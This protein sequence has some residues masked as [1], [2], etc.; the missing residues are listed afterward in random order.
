MSDGTYS[1]SLNS[2]Y[3][4]SQ[5]E[6]Q[7][8]SFSEI[9]DDWSPEF[10]NSGLMASYFALVTK[11]MH[12]LNTMTP[13]V[14]T[15]SDAMVFPV[16]VINDAAAFP[17]K[18]LSNATTI[19]VAIIENFLTHPG[20]SLSSAGNIPEVNQGT[21]PQVE[22]RGWKQ[23]VGQS[24][25]TARLEAITPSL[26]NNEDEGYVPPTPQGKVRAVRSRLK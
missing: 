26:A 22:N 18:T 13:L 25:Y 4:R 24:E 21:T 15:L 11:H 5:I 19:P 8:F 16:A 1:P 14:G 23:Y 6:A 7:E 3:T 2:I 9:T 10:E 20:V 12:S 17:I